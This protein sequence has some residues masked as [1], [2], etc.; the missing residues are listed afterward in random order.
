MPPPDLPLVSPLDRA[1]VLRAQPYFAALDPPTIT[2][3]AAL[4]VERFARPGEWL[5]HE[6]ESM[7]QIAF[8]IEGTVSLMREGESLGEVTAPSGLG[9]ASILADGGWTPGIVATTPTTYLALDV[10]SFR[11]LLAERFAFVRQIASALVREAPLPI[12]RGETPG[13]AE[14]E[15]SIVS[16]LIVAG[17]NP[18]FADL[19]LI[20][21]L[22]LLRA[23]TD[24][25]LERGAGYA[26]KHDRMLLV[27]EGA[28]RA[29]SGPSHPSVEAGDVMGL[30]VLLGG[31]R[32]ET[33]WTAREAT[34]IVEIPGSAYYDLLEG[35]AHA[36]ASLLRYLARRVFALS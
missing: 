14:G 18:I 31:A 11:R 20:A 16:T 10:R 36:A 9:L 32:M 25:E 30:D 7:S 19:N 5:H 2:A 13:R 24:L 26:T 35:H 29:S 23:S 33:S 34:R 27:V 8:L 15:P 4:S 3:L 1:L 17:H 22:E 12:I 6:G 28:L 21:L